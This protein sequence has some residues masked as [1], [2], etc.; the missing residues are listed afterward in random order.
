MSKKL[1]LIC[2]S[3]C[4]FFTLQ[5][6]TSRQPQ[7]SCGYDAPPQQWE[8]WFQTQI[9]KYKAEQATSKHLVVHTIPVVVHIIHTNETIG[10]FPNIDSNQVKSQIAVLNND[11]AGTGYNVANLPS[12]FANL[13]AN[14]GFVFCRAKKDIQDNPMQEPGIHRVSAIA[15]S[16]QAPGTPTL[17]LKAYMYSTII[18]ATIWDPTKYLN[19]WI[20]DKPAG[21]PLNGFG[22]YPAGSGLS[23]LFGNNFGTALT[24]GIWIYTKAFGT[25]GVSAPTDYGR[26]TTHELGHWLGLRHIWGDGN[27]LSD[28][29]NDTPTQKHAYYGCPTVPTASDQ[30]GVN[31][32]PNG[33]MPFNF[34]DMTDDQCKYMFTN[35]Q[36]MRMQTAF[37]QCPFRYTLGTHNKCDGPLPST[38]SSAVA[39]FYANSSQCIGS[40]F[41]PQNTSSGYPYPTYLWSSSPPVNFNPNGNVSHPAITIPSAG[42]YT[43]SLVTTNSLSSSTATM[44]ITATGSCATLPFCLDTI[45]M[46]K[47]IDTLTSYAAPNGG[48]SGCQTGFVGYLAGTNCYKDKEVAQYYP[49]SSYT[50]TP[51]PQV[52]SVIVLFDSLGTI[53][54]NDGTQIYCKIYG[55]T[56][57]QGPIGLIDQKNDSIGKITSTPKVTS[58]GYWGK[59]Y[60]TPKNNTKII[61]FKFDFNV[62]VVINNNSGFFAAVQGPVNSPPDSIN[63]M[64]NTKYN[65]SVDSSAWFLNFTN[66]WRTFR[67]NRGHKVQLAIF[68]QITCGPA[69]GIK[70]QSEL[71][72]NVMV[73]PNPNSGEFNIV[74][75]FKHEQELNLRIFNSMGQE[76]QS[77]N[78]KNIMNNVINVDLSG[79]SNGIYFAEVSNGQDVVVKKIVISH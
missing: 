38:T 44:V 10:T 9:E 27:C 40:P 34:M 50:S 46:I 7:N 79:E 67:Y 32:S 15:N 57:A 48:L 18:P 73:V 19:I 25:T 60:Q 28:Y 2:F 20:S 17:D 62:P 1:Q 45:R 59:P 11:F 3:L 43:L 37:S 52:N 24:D 72:S 49:P 54:T 58:T 30:C 31:T 63:V 61:P 16:W 64:T 66:N 77:S 36:N 75:T 6:Q 23:G 70:E 14:T 41:I 74:F 21:Y 26:T 68:P 42:T 53:S 35:D 65:S 22:T 33:E 13:K 69:V 55:G 56:G 12:V 76:I 71:A 78:M 51:Y 29:V 4:T 39:A 5:A 47:N 8:D